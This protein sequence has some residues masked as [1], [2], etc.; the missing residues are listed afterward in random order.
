MTHFSGLELH[1]H[2]SEFNGTFS[3]LILPEDPDIFP[4]QERIKRTEAFKVNNYIL[5][6][7]CVLLRV[8]SIFMLYV[9]AY[10]L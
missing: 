5:P 9:I 10:M 4:C 6:Y 1:Q 3:L 8:V 2:L 7:I